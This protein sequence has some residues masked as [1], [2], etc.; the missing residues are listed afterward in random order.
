MLDR[1]DLLL[2]KLSSLAQVTVTE[3]PDHMD[4]VSFGD[5]AKPLVEGT[6]VNWPQTLTEAAGGRLGALLALT[7]PEGALTRLQDSA[8]QR[9]QRARE[10]RQRTAHRDA[11]LLGRRPPRR[12]RWPSK[13]REVQTSSRTKAAG[14][15]EVALAIAG[16]A[17]RRQPNRATP[18]WSSRSAATCRAPRTNETNLQTTVTAINDQRQSVSGR[19][20]R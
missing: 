10:H 19:L 16:A 9:R 18:R 6:T 5:A 12:S 11:V 14:G 15:N 1:R 2:D 8:R 17:R 20:A 3:Q 13:P 7:G 4:T